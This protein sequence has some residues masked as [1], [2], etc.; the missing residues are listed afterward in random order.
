MFVS[1]T[2]K[3][4]ALF[5]DFPGHITVGLALLF[6]TFSFSS[7]S[8]FKQ[9]KEYE[10]FVH[11]RFT[12]RD[13]KVLSIAGIDV[14]QKRK[15][16]DLDFG[17]MITLGLRFFKGDLPSVIKLTVQ[18]QNTADEVAAISG[19][20]WILQAKSDTLATGVLSQP[21]T[22]P[23]RETVFFPIKVNF[24]LS[25]LLKSGS[26]NQMLKI[27]L[28]DGGKVEYEK[29][30]LVLKIKPWYRLGSKKKKSPV[31]LSIHPEFK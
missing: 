29:L 2:H 21:V 7:C 13:V 19:M 24:N 20:D 17:Q 18:G 23:P 16:S 9:A 14:S 27:I 31:Y 3:N 28:G 30:G 15:T 22:I 11:S 10:L 25:K 8:L 12:V 26:L 5:P 1:S 6:L 4:R